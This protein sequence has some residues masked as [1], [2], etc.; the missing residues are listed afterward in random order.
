MKNWKKP[1]ILVVKN[2][3]I[4]GNG[5]TSFTY[6]DVCQGGGCVTAN[7]SCVTDCAGTLVTYETGLSSNGFTCINSAGTAAAALPFCS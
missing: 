1:T 5:A 2:N 6:E 4:Q 7:G 3:T